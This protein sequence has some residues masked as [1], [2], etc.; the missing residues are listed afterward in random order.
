MGL[1]SWLLQ[2]TGFKEHLPKENV[3]QG[4]SVFMGHGDVDPM[5]RYDLAVTTKELLG[6][7]GYEVTL[8][9]YR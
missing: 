4:T 5:V 9:T 8:E 1:S 7:M 6:K 3:N 2:S